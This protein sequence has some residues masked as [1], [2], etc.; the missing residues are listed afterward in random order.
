MTEGQHNKTDR[1]AAPGRFSTKKADPS[2]SQLHSRSGSSRSYGNIGHKSVGSCG[3]T[4]PRLRVALLALLASSAIVT[5]CND[6]HKQGNKIASADPGRFITII[7]TGP[8]GNPDLNPG[9][10]EDP[11]ALA[12]LPKG[13]FLVLTGENGRVF[14]VQTN[15]SYKQGFTLDQPGRALSIGVRS[16]GSIVVAQE[17]QA[18]GGIALWKLQQ[19]QPPQKIDELPKPRNMESIHLVRD[20]EGKL[21]LLDDGRLLEGDTRDRYHSTPYTKALG[22]HGTV[23]AAAADDTKLMLLLPDAL[24]WMENDKIARRV[25]VPKMDARDGASISPDGSGGAYKARYG[26]AIDHYSAQ[27]REGAVLLGYGGSSGCGK[28]KVSGPTG[29]GREHNFDRATALLKVEG[30]LFF[31]DPGCH[32]VLAMGLPTKE[33]ALPN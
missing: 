16:D 12:T 28:G 31:T 30:Q 5:S 11:I 15:G 21:L 24:I 20:P 26:P 13:G 18:T 3:M 22:S 2:D 8:D 14:S 9:W 4:M 23:L 19:G 29:D 32:R 17:L 6:T 27:G 7:G 33:Y 1:S 25:P 10:F